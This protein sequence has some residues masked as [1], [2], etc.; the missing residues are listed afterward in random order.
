MLVRVFVLA[1]AFLLA[2]ATAARAQT[3]ITV[4]VGDDDGF[5]GT[6]GAN[7]NPG[8]V[9]IP[10]SSPSIA[11]GTHL[12]TNGQDASTMAPWTPY[13]FIFDFATNFLAPVPFESITMSVQVGS[14]ARRTDG[15]GFGHANVSLRDIITDDTL[16]LGD[17]LTVSTGDT[18]SA[19]EE[20]VR[21]PTWDIQDFFLAHQDSIIELII[22]GTGLANPADQFAIDMAYIE[23]IFP[24]ETTTT[25]PD[26]TTTLPDTTTT[27]PPST[28]TTIV[29]TT[30]LTSTTTSTLPE[31]MCGTAPRTGCKQAGQDKASIQIM[32]PAD[33]AKRQ[34]KWKWKGGD[35]TAVAEF[36]DPVSDDPAYSLCV[37][38]SSARSQPL[39][40]FP[41][42]LG[43]CEDEP[44]WKQTGSGFK[45]KSKTESSS[46]SVKL[47]AGPAGKSQVSVISKGSDLDLPTLPLT[48]PVTVQFVADTGTSVTCWQT[49]FT[50]AK[51]NDADTYQAKGP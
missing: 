34:I 28:T 8:D 12:N 44:C 5:G 35:V 21:L 30:T 3:S 6:Q 26:P 46:A 18:G 43:T 25:L 17:L 14:V 41:I 31:P 19:E 13:K 16:D 50:G 20:L 33:P 45:F 36:G 38:D 9:F 32:S 47:K 27:E 37:Y 4:G 2:L 10:F 49:T 29:T 48:E 11:P 51:K 1:T 24:A 39:I 40:Q 22:D 23:V 42:P 15:S 7:S